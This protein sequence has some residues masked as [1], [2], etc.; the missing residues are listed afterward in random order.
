MVQAILTMLVAIISSFGFEPSSH[1]YS[2]GQTKIATGTS[3]T[4][5]IG[6]ATV[7]RSDGVAESWSIH[8]DGSVVDSFL[9]QGFPWLTLQI[10]PAGSASFGEE[11]TAVTR[12]A[13]QMEVFWVGPDGSVQHAWFQ[14][15]AGWSTGQLEPAGS[16]ATNGAITAI[17]RSPNTM[18]L[19]WTTSDGSV[20]YASFADGAGW[21]T[22]TKIAPAGNA[23]GCNCGFLSY[24]PSM[25]AVSVTPSTIDV[26]WITPEG[27]VENAFNLG[28]GWKLAT[29]GDSDIAFTG[30]GL[31]ATVANGISYVFFYGTDQSI[32][33]IYAAQDPTTGFLPYL[34]PIALESSSVALGLSGMSAISP[35]STQ[36]DLF[37]AGKDGALHWDSYN[38]AIRHVTIP[39]TKNLTGLTGVSA[40]AEDADTMDVMFTGADYA[41]DTVNIKDTL[42]VGVIN[43]P[44]NGSTI[45]T[46]TPTISITDPGGGSPWKATKVT[47]TIAPTGPGSSGSYSWDVTPDDNGNWSGSVPFSLAPSKWQLKMVSANDTGTST[48]YSNFTVVQH[49]PPPPT[50]VTPADGSVNNP[51]NVKFYFKDP[52]AGTINAA[53]EF[54]F[55]VTQNNVVIN[56]G[57]PYPQPWI[58]GPDTTAAPMTSPGVTWGFSIA[59]GTYQVEAWSLNG[60]GSSNGATATFTVGPGCV[61]QGFAAGSNQCCSGLQKNQAGACEPADPPGCGITT[62]GDAP[63]CCRNS[64]PC[65]GNGTCVVDPSNGYAFCKPNDATGPGSAPTQ[66]QTGGSNSCTLLNCFVNCDID[67]DFECEPAGLFCSAALAEANYNAMFGAH[68]CHGCCGPGCTADNCDE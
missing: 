32:Q 3:T 7:S 35:T 22:P 23:L 31:T 27:A 49:A 38:G 25:K 26:Y 28:S 47:L 29:L 55:V 9:I 5:G 52:A 19:F 43:S 60:A 67:T 37:F 50:I 12:S 16:A 2:T 51:N 46:A 59:N 15:Y 54:Q 44:A 21:A 64:T 42:A 66:A 13:N 11:I 40:A 39:P 10:A 34:G 63:P 41:D 58:T 24:I 30:G 56:S 62:I 17:T 18:D 1:A 6:S 68:L 33:M 14:Q 57:P 48:T 53:T 65:T 4:S 61:Q 20:E 36:W 45:N 8:G